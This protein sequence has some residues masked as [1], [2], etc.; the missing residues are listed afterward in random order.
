VVVYSCFWNKEAFLPRG[1]DGSNGSAQPKT[2]FTPHQQSEVFFWLIPHCILL[3]VKKMWD[4][5]ERM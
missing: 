4:F 1:F 3:C 2:N 5:L